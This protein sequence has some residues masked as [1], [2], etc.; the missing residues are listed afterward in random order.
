MIY[1]IKQQVETDCSSSI[2]LFALIVI[3][4]NT[5]R[6]EVIY[7]VTPVTTSPRYSMP[8]YSS[9]LKGLMTDKYISRLKPEENK[10]TISSYKALIF[11]VADTDR[12]L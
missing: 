7:M 5:F 6:N 8:S 3:R 12:Q 4:W 11:T 2:K 10:A 9:S 1:H